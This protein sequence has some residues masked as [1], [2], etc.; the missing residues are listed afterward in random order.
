MGLR[1]EL[2]ESL[3]PTLKRG[4]SNHCAYGA[5]ARTLLMQCSI[6]PGRFVVCRRRGGGANTQALGGDAVRHEGPAH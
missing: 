1:N 5:F 3:F 4:A 6:K 2:V